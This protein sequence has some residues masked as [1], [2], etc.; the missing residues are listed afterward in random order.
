MLQLLSDKQQAIIQALYLLGSVQ[1]ADVER[2]T[3]ARS[4]LSGHTFVLCMFKTMFP[5]PPENS[6]Q[7]ETPAV[8]VRFF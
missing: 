2:K 8:T 6:A 5:L 7:S 4:T 1:K 3:H